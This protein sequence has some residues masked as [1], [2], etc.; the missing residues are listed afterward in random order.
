MQTKVILVPGCRRRPLAVLLLIAGHLG[1]IG[2]LA[3][4]DRVQGRSAPASR[5]A[6]RSAPAS[7]ELAAHP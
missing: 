3:R 2:L 1:A 4:D 5:V 7:V 6:G